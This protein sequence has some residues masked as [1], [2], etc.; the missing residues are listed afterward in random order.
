MKI[1][2]ISGRNLELYSKDFLKNYNVSIIASKAQ[3]AKIPAD[4]KVFEATE[5]YDEISKTYTFNEME[6]RNIINTVK[7]ERIV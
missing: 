6:V 5:Y 7:P 2:L 1:L 4:M 3:V